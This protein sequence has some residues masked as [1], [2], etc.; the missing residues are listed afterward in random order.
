MPVNMVNIIKRKK[1]AA[2][3]T[4][5]QAGPAASQAASPAE[6]RSIH[7]AC[8]GFSWQVPGIRTASSPRPSAFSPLTTYADKTFSSFYSVTRNMQGFESDYKIIPNVPLCALYLKFTEVEFFARFMGRLCVHPH[9]GLVWMTKSLSMVTPG[10]LPTKPLLALVIL[11]WQVILALTSSTLVSMP[12][13]KWGWKSANP[14]ASTSFFSLTKPWLY[15][16]IW[17]RPLRREKGRDHNLGMVMGP[18]CGHWDISRNPLGSPGGYK[19]SPLTR[20]WTGKEM[21]CVT[22]P[23]FGNNWVKDTCSEEPG[24]SC[25]CTWKVQKTAEIGISGY[26]GSPTW[27]PDIVDLPNHHQ[28]ITCG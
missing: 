26:L 23:C 25:N 20:G 24:P 28:H 4:R 17:Q 8:L 5:E 12:E 3:S 6:K 19:L 22:G 13:S 2:D 27:S 7:F 18:R 1:W 16:N 15:S 10:K 9:T 14:M 21:L 11:G